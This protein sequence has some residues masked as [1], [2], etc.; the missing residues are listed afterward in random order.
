MNRDEAIRL[1]KAGETGV[2]EWNRWV[3]EAHSTEPFD[4][5]GAD[6]SGSALNGIDLTNVKL[7]EANL[8]GA[9]LSFATLSYAHLARANLSG[10]K[11][12]DSTLN[13][14]VLIE[15]NLV[16]ADLW[17]SQLVQADCFEANL[18]GSVLSYAQLFRANL[19]RANLKNAT[20][21]RTD[22]RLACMAQANLNGASLA[23]CSVYGTSVWDANLEAAEQSNLFLEFEPVTTID[24]PGGLSG[25]TWSPGTKITLDDIELAHFIYLL[26]KNKNVRKFIDS[27]NSRAVLILGRFTSERKAVLEIVREELRRRAYLPILFDFEPPAARDLTET[28]GTLAHLAR[29]I[30]ADLTDPSSVPHELATI[31]PHLRTVPVATLIE[32]GHEPYAMFMDLMSY[33]W[34]LRPVEYYRGPPFTDAIDRLVA[35]AEEKVAELRRERFKK[36]SL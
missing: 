15:A 11:L 14:T 20:L 28:I 9:E 36:L 34:V 23:E 1:L 27:M 4:L 26:L 2:A 13:R 12:D 33:P 24:L 3:R 5:S 21:Y 10:A 32:S 22:L 6:L 29:F 7:T 17:C 25:R 16:G 8:C 31:V 35:L 30:L 18:E 19:E